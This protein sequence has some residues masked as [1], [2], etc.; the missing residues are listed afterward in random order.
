MPSP[1]NN[2][3]KRLWEAADQLRANS[4]LTAQEYSR[5]VLGLIFLKY[6][7]YRFSLAET[8]L[9]LKGTDTGSLVKLQYQA[10]GVLYLPEKARFSHLIQLPEG[11][12]IGKAI[13]E[14]MEAIER[15]NEDIRG[16]LPREYQRLENPLLVELLK[17]FNSI[18]MDIEGDV[19][20]KINEYFLGKFAMTEGRG[21][22]EFYTPTS[23]VRLIVNIIE[24]YHGRIYDPA[25]GSGG[26]FIQ[27][28][29]FVEEH[30]HSATKELTLF[31]QEFKDHTVRL[32]RMNLAVHGLPTEGIK[33]GNTYYED[34]HNSLGRF[35][36]VM[37]NPPFNVNGV[38]KERI[39]DD[40][41]Y[42]LGIPRADNA[43][44]LWIQDFYSALN[45]KGRAGFVMT[46][47]AADAR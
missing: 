45:D 26:M 24:P 42:V 43:N 27:S 8:E 34:Q 9:G 12:D 39:K 30:Q 15:E 32:C 20:G 4:A 13:N 3:E 46:N 10:R 14:A 28:A 2:L 29:R 19:F 11:S 23:I 1:N 21:G 33:Q 17:I 22:G 37:A 6:A 40:P 36:F 5:P 25:C 41:R 7:D 16:V 31:G 47:S 18:S 44:Y 38:D 35:D